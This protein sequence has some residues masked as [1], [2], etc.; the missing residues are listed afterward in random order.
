MA[1]MNTLRRGFRA[2]SR[3]KPYIKAGFK[4]YGAYKQFKNQSN[5]RTQTQNRV[6]SGVGVTTQKDV[7][8][9]YRRKRMPRRKRKRWVKF[10]KKVHA[11]TDSAIATRSVIFNN[12]LQIGG[13]DANQTTG[14]ISLYGWRGSVATDAVGTADVRTITQRDG[15][16]DEQSEKWRF[17]SGV[18]DCTASNI[19]GAPLEVDVYEVIKT[20]KGRT[21]NGNLNLEYTSALTQTSVPPAGAGGS[22]SSPTIL[23]RGWTPFNCSLASAKGLKVIKKTK[24]FLPEGETFTYQIR[25][26][27]NHWVGGEDIN[28]ASGNEFARNG[29][30]RMLFIIAKSVVGT[31]AETFELLVGCTRSYHYKIYNGNKHYEGNL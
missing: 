23:T 14:V 27:K 1:M 30:T 21:T 9:T 29:M 7:R 3:Y 20:G 31:T 12:T 8:T 5:T 17:T 22:L 26:P 13:T 28:D 2:A 6:R 18:L 25:D 15:D 24:Y 10:V 19:G 11:A 4:A 16:V